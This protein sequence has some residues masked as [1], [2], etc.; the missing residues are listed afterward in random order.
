MMPK[1]DGYQV[2]ERLKSEGRLHNIP[3]VMISALNEIASMV[4]CI[5]LGAE[6]YLPK[7][8]DPV[9]LRSRVAA[10]LEKK[11]P[12]HEVS[13]HPERVEA[14][15]QSA[16]QLQMTMLPNSFPPPCTHRAIEIF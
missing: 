8:F 7:P 14:E 16:P 5:A 13:A 1:L 2:L 12:R 10:S 6:D 9:L 15:L 4:R 3:V 11:T